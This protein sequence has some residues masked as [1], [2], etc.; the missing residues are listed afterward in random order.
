MPWKLL[1]GCQNISFQYVQKI[2]WR[3]SMIKTLDDFLKNFLNES[4]DEFLTEQ[5]SK[6]INLCRC[7]Q[8][9]SRKNFLGFPVKMFEKIFGRIFK[10]V[11]GKFFEDII[12]NFLQK[13]LE[14]FLMES[15]DEYLE[16]SMEDF[17]KEPLKNK[18]N[19]WENC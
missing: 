7:S 11:L 13:F 5:R 10:K 19:H 18:K 14:G 15:L 6:Q 12:E 2:S 17:P 4:V 1:M 9:I 16:K 3:N 8:K